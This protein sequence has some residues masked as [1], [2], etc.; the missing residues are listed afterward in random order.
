MCFSFDYTVRPCLIHTCH[1]M[2]SVNQTRP[3]CVNQM[4]K[5]HSK[6][7]MARHGRRTA[8][9]RHAM[10]ESVFK[11]MCDNTLPFPVFTFFLYF[12]LPI[13]IFISVFP[14]LL[15]LCSLRYSFHFCLP[16]YLLRFFSLSLFWLFLSLLLLL[17]SVWRQTEQPVA[18]CPLLQACVISFYPLTRFIAV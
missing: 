5:T 9:A 12:W 11:G 13:Y 16:L 15:V 2:A 10:C 17:M 14:S 8:W 3:H 4:G 18:L 1:G 6:P 7:L